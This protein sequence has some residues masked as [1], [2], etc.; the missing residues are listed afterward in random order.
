MIIPVII[1]G[2]QIKIELGKKLLA[3][4]LVSLV[5]ITIT[6][7]AFSFI[8]KVSLSN[9]GYVECTGIPTGWTPRMATKYALDISQCNRSVE[10]DPN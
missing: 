6:M 9:R 3:F 2:R 7:L 10:H 4:S 1:Y 8:Y 5:L